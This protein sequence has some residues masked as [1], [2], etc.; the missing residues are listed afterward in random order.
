MLK[1]LEEFAF[2]GIPDARGSAIEHHYDNDDMVCV[3]ILI[4]IWMIIII[5][6][7]NRLE[8]QR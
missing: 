3:Q 8:K 5:P 7:G 6:R 1:E 4:L 2:K